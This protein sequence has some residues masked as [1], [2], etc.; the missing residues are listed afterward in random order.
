LG[1]E[2]VN[3]V[4]PGGTPGIA[5]PPPEGNFATFRHYDTFAHFAR[6]RVRPGFSIARLGGR[7]LLLYACEPV[8]S[9]PQILRNLPARR[10]GSRKE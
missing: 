3:D 9:L 1:A 8:R 6:V 10:F 7:Y 2:V 5:L 4:P